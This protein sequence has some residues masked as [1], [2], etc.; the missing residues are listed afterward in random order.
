MTTILAPTTDTTQHTASILT[1][2]DVLDIQCALQNAAATDCTTL[3]T[4]DR[5]ALALLTYDR[6][7]CKALPALLIE[8][9]LDGTDALP[10]NERRAGLLLRLIDRLPAVTDDD[11]DAWLADRDI[12]TPSTVDRIINTLAAYTATRTGDPGYPLQLLYGA[13]QTVIR[14]GKP[15]IPLA[16]IPVIAQAELATAL[17]E[18]DVDGLI[19]PP[20]DDPVERAEDRKSVV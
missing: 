16:D 15:S 8:R 20:Q 5:Q 3:N 13:L 4:A 19:L 18:L 9:I 2:A 17:A 10:V 6:Q 14:V 1:P 11:V 12:E 7:T